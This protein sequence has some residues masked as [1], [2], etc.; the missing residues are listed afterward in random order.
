L[1]ILSQKGLFQQTLKVMAINC[2]NY[3]TLNLCYKPRGE[4]NAWFI[5]Y[6]SSPN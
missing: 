5:L 1:P 3:L 2:D 6:G 4:R